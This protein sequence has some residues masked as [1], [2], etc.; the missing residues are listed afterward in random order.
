MYVVW[1]ITLVNELRFIYAKIEVDEIPWRWKVW[2]YVS[3]FPPRYHYPFYYPMKIKTYTK[4]WTSVH[5]IYCVLAIAM[6][7]S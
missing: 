2:K 6:L 1:N 7:I 3:P 4:Y 5:A